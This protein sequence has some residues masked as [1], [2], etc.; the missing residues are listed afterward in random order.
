L[1]AGAAVLAAL[2]FG[3]TLW[4]RRRPRC[5]LQRQLLDRLRAAAHEEQPR[6]AAA[7]AESAWRDYL[8]ERWQIPRGFPSTQWE[9]ALGSHG[10]DPATARELVL[11]MDDLH[12]LRYAPQLATTGPLHGELLPRSRQLLRQLP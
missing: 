9:G 3:A 1:A 7:A 8:A 11:L 6:Q 5:R 10:V 4:R 2:P 12:Y